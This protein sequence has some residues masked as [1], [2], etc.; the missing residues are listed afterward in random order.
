MRR[1][2]EPV[3]E[4]PVKEVSVP[5]IAEP[6]LTR[7]EKA[8]LARKNAIAAWHETETP[9]QKRAAVKQFPILVSMYSIAQNYK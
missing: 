4:E 9:E 5:V 8:D 6:V 7:E 3:T 2:P 1:K